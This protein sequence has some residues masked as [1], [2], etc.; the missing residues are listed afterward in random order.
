[1]TVAQ[2]LFVGALWSGTVDR[3][4]R[5]LLSSFLSITASVAVD[6]L[7]PVTSASLFS[8]LSWLFCSLEPHL[9]STFALLSTVL[10]FGP[11]LFIPYHRSLTSCHDALTY[12]LELGVGY[13]S[14]KTSM[15]V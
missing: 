15:A 7:L 9:R 11:A 14:H 4:P 2:L 8:G 5:P 12:G 13:G 10:P 6:F 1:M 3:S